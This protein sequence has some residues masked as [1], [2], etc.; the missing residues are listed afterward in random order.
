VQL[1][2]E[3]IDQT[4]IMEYNLRSNEYEKKL[5]LLENA[6]KRYDTLK[7]EFDSLRSERK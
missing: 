6:S 2:E 3:A 1:I 4:L 7:V 5:G